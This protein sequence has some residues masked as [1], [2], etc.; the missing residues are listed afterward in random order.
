MLVDVCTYHINNT[1]IHFNVHVCM[2][3]SDG[4]PSTHAM[5]LACK[6]VVA[7]GQL[8]DHQFQL[9]TNTNGDT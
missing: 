2:C 8:E 4:T 7:T 3:T 9:M 1:Q 6:L 5:D